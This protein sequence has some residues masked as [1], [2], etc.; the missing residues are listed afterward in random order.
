MPEVAPAPVRRLLP[1]I[2]KSK[3]E[4]ERKK[5]WGDRDRMS[6]IFGMS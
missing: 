4:R 2:Y 5:K 6:N 1:D 3:K